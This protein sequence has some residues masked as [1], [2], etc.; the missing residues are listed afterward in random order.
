[1]GNTFIDPQVISDIVTSQVPEKIKFKNIA[2]VN[3]ELVGQPGSKLTMVA[4]GYIG[5]AE[6]IVNLGDSITVGEMQDTQVDVQIKQVGRAV[7]IYDRELLTGFGKPLDRAADQISTSIANKVD[8]DCFNVLEDAVLLK[9]LSTDTHLTPTAVSKGLTKYGENIAGT[10]VLYVSA[11]QLAD[12]RADKAYIEVTAMKEIISGDVVGEIWGCQLII[13]DRIVPVDGVVTN[14][15]VK[16]NSISLIMK[17]DADVE[18][19]RQASKKLTELVGD[20]HYVAYLQDQSGVIKLK[21]AETP[22]V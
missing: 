17:R 8:K 15:I 9:D 14:Y 4:Y 1:M 10:K 20:M 21:V 2:Q 16:Q 13:S 22:V 12:L 3:N 5:D 18:P 19:Q 11:D 7:N 6:E